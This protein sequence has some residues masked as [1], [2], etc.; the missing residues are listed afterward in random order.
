VHPYR[1]VEVDLATGEILGSVTLQ[2][3]ELNQQLPD[4]YFEDLASIVP[5]L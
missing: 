4:V 2:S 1:V 3:V 5:E